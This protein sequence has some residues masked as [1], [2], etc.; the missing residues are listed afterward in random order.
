MSEVAKMMTDMIF[1][2][3]IDMRTGKMLGG[4]TESKILKMIR[5]CN[6]R[7]TEIT[8]ERSF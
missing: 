3:R 4:M 8:G 5:K 7:F 2:R 1:E 6:R